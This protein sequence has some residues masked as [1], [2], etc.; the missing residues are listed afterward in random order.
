[1]HIGTARTAVFNWLYARNQG[2]KFILRIED[3]DE[4]RSRPE[5]TENILDGLDWLELKWDEGP[6]YQSGRNEIYRKAI[7]KLIDKGLAYRCYCSEE[8]LEQ[9]R[10][11][12]RAKG[13]APRYDNRHRKL[14][15]QQQ[16][17]FEAEG[18]QP[19][20]R[21]KIDDDRQI[22]WKD[23]VRGTVTWKGSDLGGDLVIA[24]AASGGKIGRP[25]YNMAVVVD[26]LEMGITHVI[27]GEDHIG[28]TP[29]QILLYEALEGIVPEFAHTPLILN[30]E[31]R[32][33]SKRDGVTSISEFKELG[34]TPEAIAN[35][36]CLLGWTPPDSTQ[37]IFTI[38]EAAKQFSFDRVNKAGAKFDW[39]KLDWINSQYL[40]AMAVSELTDRLIPFWQKAGLEFDPKSD[41]SWLE[42]LAAL[43]GPS[44]T[45][46]TDA[47]EMSKLFFTRT[48]EADKE[49]AAQLAKEDAANVISTILENIEGDGELKTNDANKII[50][51]VTQQIKVKKGVVMRTLRAALTGSM[52]GPDLIQSW[53]LLHQRGFDVV[54]FKKALGQDIEEADIVVQ[55]LNPKTPA[56]DE[57]KPEQKL[58]TAPAA[59][60]P[61]EE[62]PTAAAAKPAEEKPA[63]TAAKPVEEKPAPAAAKPAEEKPAPAAAKPAEEKPTPAAAKP[64]EEKPT[65]AAAKPTE[66]KPTPTAAKPVEEKPAAAAAK[67]VEEKPAAAAAKPAEE[68]PA[69][70]AAKPAE[71]KP[72]P[73]AAKPVEEKPAPAAAPVAAT[74]KPTD[75]KPPTSPTVAATPVRQEAKPPTP[76]VVPAA[77][78]A[79]TAKPEVKAP[80][81]SDETRVV[82]E[83]SANLTPVE[84]IEL[85]KQVEDDAIAQTDIEQGQES[86][87]QWQQIKDETIKILSDLPGYLNNFYQQ[88]KKPVNITG[89]ILASAIALR[90]I[91]A[92]VEAV[93]SVPLLAFSFE[94]IGAGYSAWF[95]FRYLL[96]ASDRQDLYDDIKAFKKEIFGKDSE[97]LN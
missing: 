25:L 89:T 1:L 68:K 28:N 55:T 65:P 97:D 92:V 96:K 88:Y 11:S 76:P 15:P 5:Y 14:T 32:K 85:A 64:T 17:A 62:K 39:D 54:R 36:M 2:G 12:Q 21:F 34:F 4:E 94:L 90:V 31:G 69:P 75:V 71:E 82:K 80:K 84:K 58:A 87:F 22:T 10:L 72:A 13:Q 30:K 24:R 66:E 67:P 46:L 61:A 78:P 8:E 91:V 60:K 23:M 57:V 50:K 38:Q 29:K 37:E 33:L 19:V 86:S 79:A 74:S 83:Q 49:A 81:P 18:R 51:R 35:Y 59:A 6:Y 44:L 95:V 42:E 20:I 26:D 47:V 77:P 56:K 63:P 9:M 73:T 3:T 52:H 43:I 40:H 27:R 70:T 93:E 7:Q 41:R 45:R 16:A 48:V 53:L